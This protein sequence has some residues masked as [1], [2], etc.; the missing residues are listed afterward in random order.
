MTKW[1]LKNILIICLAFAVCV[2]SWSIFTNVQIL[3]SIRLKMS[4]EY[5]P[6]HPRIHLSTSVHS[7][8]INKQQWARSTGSHTFTSLNTASQMFDAWCGALAHELFLYFSRHSSSSI[9]KIQVYL[10]FNCPKNL[11]PE[12]ES[13]FF[14]QHNFLQSLTWPSCWRKLPVVCPLL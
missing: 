14:F 4:M 12:L 7:H 6:I 10:A 1:I 9:I 5:S 2:G 3:C 8:T 11:I 13:L